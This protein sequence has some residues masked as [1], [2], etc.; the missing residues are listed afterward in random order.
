M[1]FPQVINLE[2]DAVMVFNGDSVINDTDQLPLGTDHSV[3][4]ID[5]NFKLL[6]LKS[7]GE[8]STSSPITMTYESTLDYW[9]IRISDLKTQVG[10]LFSDTDKTKYVGRVTE[11]AGGTDDMRAFK[12]EEFA[13]DNESFTDVWMDLPYQIEI[14]VTESWMVWYEDGYI[15]TAGYEKFKAPAY[16]DGIGTTYATD[17][18]RVTHRG[19]I[20]KI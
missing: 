6:S 20:E 3:T 11:E 17:P 10:F 2:T 13:I 14:G 19:A 8:L 18:A 16:E 9:S 15:N 1:K 4:S 5:V 7:G 12:I